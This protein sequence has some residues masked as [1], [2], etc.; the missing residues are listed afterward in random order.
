[1]CTAAISAFGIGRVEAVRSA[2]LAATTPVTPAASPVASPSPSPGA[3]RVLR[4]PGGNI[5]ARCDAG[6]TWADAL[7]PALGFHVEGAQQGPAKDYRVTFKTDGQEVRV[8]IR[9]TDL[10]PQAEITLG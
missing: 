10:T 1:M 2:V 5:V 4:T 3:P 7:S 8:V 6:L 9:C